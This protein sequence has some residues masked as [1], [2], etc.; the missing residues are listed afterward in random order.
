MKEL[1]TNLDQ[2]LLMLEQQ[3]ETLN[4]NYIALTKEYH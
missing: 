2:E 1:K 4:N 3:A